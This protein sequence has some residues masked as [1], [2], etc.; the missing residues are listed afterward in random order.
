MTGKYFA[1]VT[2]E[3]IRARML[4]IQA[5]SVLPVT[6]T[7]AVYL[8]LCLYATSNVREVTCTNA[9]YVSY[10]CAQRVCATSNAQ[11][12]CTRNYTLRVMQKSCIHKLCLS[13]IQTVH[14]S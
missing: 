14:D 5:T 6:C 12:Q 1:H 3:R 11:A 10:G 9:A 13:A 8:R 4:Y 2:C 7:N